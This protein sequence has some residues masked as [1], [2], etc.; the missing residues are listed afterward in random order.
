MPARAFDLLEAK[1]FG[2]ERVT[3]AERMRR[4]QARPGYGNG[5]GAG[6][7]EVARFKA[8]ADIV[9]GWDATGARGL[10]EVW[11]KIYREA[12]AP[13]PALGIDGWADLYRQIAPEFSAAPGRWSTSRVPAMRDVMRACGP[14]HPC[15]RVV[16]VK[17]VQAGG[18]EAAVL[19]VIGHTIDVWPRSM[20]L[21]FPTIE[22]AESF[23]RERLDPMIKG[24]P[25]LSARVMDVGG[26]VGRSS[27][28]KKVYP[29]GF[30]NLTGANSVSGL[31]SRAVPLVIM[32]EVDACIGN[33]GPGGNPVR[34][35]AAR[36][37]TF[38]DR[39]EIF[40]SSPLN[41]E[42]ESGI[43]Q[44][45]GESSRGQ[46]ETCCP[47][48]GSWQVLAWERM[49]I[50]RAMLA[51]AGCGEYY[52]QRAWVGRGEAAVRWVHAAPNHSTAGFR[53][54]GLNSPWLDWTRD[55]CGDFKE[56]SRLARLGDDSL[57]RV[58]FNTKLARA[59]RAGGRR[60]EA[61]LYGE[62]REVYT[63]HAAGAEV[64]AGVL[65]L[66]AAV[67][68]QDA[69]LSYEVVGWGPLR[70]SWGIEAGDCRGDP[71]APDG[72][73]WA[74][75][76]K[77]VYNRLFRYED[78]RFVR[79]R[80]IFVDSGGHCTSEVYK[81][82]RARQPRV[83]AIKGVGGAGKPIIIGGRSRERSEGAW[84]LRL[85][86]DTLKDEFHSRLSVPEPGP[87]F[88]HWPRLPN[89][90]AVAGYT[91]AYFD[92]LTAEERV[93]RYS[94][95]GYARYAWE[96]A[97]SAANEAFDTR[98]YNRAAL[99]YLKARLERMPRDVIAGLDPAAVVE[100]ELGY[101]RA[102][103]NIKPGATKKY[104]LSAGPSTAAIGADAA[105]A[106]SDIPRPRNG[107]APPTAPREG[108]RYGA[109]G[110]AF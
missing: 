64:P 72:A 97:R 70:E 49:D 37:T 63:A 27:I 15:R 50:E 51:C 77:F 23:S 96:K 55:L 62:R 30:L 6:E 92:Q 85:G 14:A 102:I 75:I 108:P 106:P 16:L 19:N 100:I 47:G 80:I 109:A 94:G 107:P 10:V 56:A 59:Y 81:Y 35:L 44:M 40:L 65:L 66:T 25:R 74:A 24:A 61:D 78:G 13:P 69:Y 12:C 21:T 60:V 68:V 76:D 1:T 88:C 90:E 57:L 53:M 32:D 93:L 20:L 73:V 38:A 33:A 46:L 104:A 54:S 71:R 3:N 7:A 110:N 101:G 17:P 91:Q 9:N 2:G 95:G 22:L 28:K 87:G 36:A 42:D 11:R 84:L 45:W 82:C 5:G 52:G 18:T 99:E 103:I 41:G 58:F 34:L 8:T 31:S 79:A 105:A 43:L 39:K 48:C 86:V 83:F 89:G 98:C 26:P 29:G 67:D 4:R